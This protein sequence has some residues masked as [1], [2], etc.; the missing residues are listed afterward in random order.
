MKE[1]Y[2]LK[3]DRLEFYEENLRKQVYGYDD[4]QQSFIFKN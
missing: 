4:C 3:H 2:L 1:N